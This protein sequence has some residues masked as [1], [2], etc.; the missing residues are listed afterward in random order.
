M[1]LPILGA[2]MFFLIM[3]IFEVI[4]F[5]R[6]D[7]HVKACV[8][9]LQPVCYSWLCAETDGTAKEM[10]PSYK[11]IFDNKQKFLDSIPTTNRPSATAN[12]TDKTNPYYGCIDPSLS[13]GSSNP[14]QKTLPTPQYSTTYTYSPGGTNQT[15]LPGSTYP[16]TGTYCNSADLTKAYQAS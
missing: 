11:A 4:I 3:T 7:V 14:T 15:V 5:L 2:T 10:T 16:T 1:N 6:A 9:P 12:A 8:V 13:Y